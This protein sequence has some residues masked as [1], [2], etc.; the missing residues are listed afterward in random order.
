MD[1][2]QYSRSDSWPRV[3]IVEED[4]VLALDTAKECLALGLEPKL[5]LGPERSTNCP[6]LKGEACPRSRGVEATFV[7]ISSGRQRMAAHS[8]RGGRVVIAAERPLGGAATV[9]TI[10]PDVQLGQPY[11]PR[12]AASALFSLVRDEP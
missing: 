7:S 11:D 4:P 2:R 12:T 6:G 9:A 8:C 10:C 3:L 1:T 5:C